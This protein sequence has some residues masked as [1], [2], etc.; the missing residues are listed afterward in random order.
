M[1]FNCVLWKSELLIWSALCLTQG[2]SHS[3]QNSS[4]HFK[5]PWLRVS[6]LLCNVLVFLH[7]SSSLDVKSVFNQSQKQPTLLTVCAQVKSWKQCKCCV[8]TGNIMGKT[9][10]CQASLQEGWFYDLC[11]LTWNSKV[12]PSMHYVHANKKGQTKRR[13]GFVLRLDIHV[14]AKPWRESLCQ[15]LKWELQRNEVLTHDY[16]CASCTA[17]ESWHSPP[18]D[19]LANCSFFLLINDQL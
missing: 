7:P 10:G 8:A 12:Y 9:N 1:C 5:Q 3:T 16:Q 13:L 19:G 4:G 2:I 6:S 14:T 17:V 15:Y 11:L 18:G